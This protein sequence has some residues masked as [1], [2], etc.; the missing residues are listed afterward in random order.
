M[1]ETDHRTGVVALLGRPN[2]GKSTLLNRL[3]GEHLAIVTRKP[4]TT[5][6]RI[7]GILNRPGVQI[8]FVDTPGLHASSKP[9]NVAMN[10]IVGEVAAD[11][12]VALLLADS[13]RGIDDDLATLRSE[14]EARGAPVLVVATKSDLPGGARTSWPGEAQPA[15]RISALTG[16]GIEALLRDVEARLP[17]SPPLYPGDELSD[18]PL[19]FLVGERVREAVFEELEQELPYEIAVEVVEYDEKREDLVRIRADLIVDRPSQKRIVIGSGGDVIKR[20]GIRA[21]RDIEQFL[22]RRVHLDLWVKVERHW[23]KH[24]KRL[25]SLGYS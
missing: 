15:H 20:I 5:R 12:D 1:T 6:S 2:A 23:A 18:R 25:K 17:V 21:R 4:Q 19:R 8:L 11:C 14:I 3:L 7:L 10:R 13:V 24:P 22:G 9:L 16:E